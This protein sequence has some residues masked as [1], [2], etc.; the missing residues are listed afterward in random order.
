MIKDRSSSC[1]QHFENSWW[2]ALVW[3]YIYSLYCTRYSVGPF[4]LEIHIPQFWNVILN[5]FFDDFLPTVF[6]MS[7]SGT[8]KFRCWTSWRGL[9]VFF[10]IFYFFVFFLSVLEKCFP[11]HLPHGNCVFHFWFIYSTSKC[12]FLFLCSLFGTLVLF[13]GSCNF[14]YSSENIN[15]S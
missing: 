2:C 9:L 12:S 8:H 7:V 10:S 4:K 11:L 1:P 3:V 6:S 13:Y 15:D 5:Y 14:S